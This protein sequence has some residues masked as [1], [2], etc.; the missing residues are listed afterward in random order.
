MGQAVCQQ[1]LREGYQVTSLSRRGLPPPSQSSS[2][3][4]SSWQ[5]QVDYRQGDATQKQSITNILFEENNGSDDDNDNNNSY[6]GIVHCI[7]LLL[8]GESGLGD[9]N[10][11]A[12]G[13]GSMVHN[14]EPNT[15]DA[16]TRQTAMNAIQ[17]AM[18]YAA[19]Q[20]QRTTTATTTR[21]PFCFTSAAEAGWP[22]VAG[23]NWIEQTLAPDWLQRYLQAKRA[24]ES[25]LLSSSSSSSSQQ[26]QH[27]QQ[28]ELLRPIIV[29]PSLIYSLDRPASYVPVG[30]F[31]MLNQLGLPFVDRPVTVQSLSKAIITSLDPESCVSGILRYPEIDRLAKGAN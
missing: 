25:Q 29:R 10:R 23:G 4:L 19:T 9:W 17:A 14:T 5:K 16:I 26:Q 27:E 21:L 6:V 15:Y 30:A 12:S 11:F 3:S 2:S 7:G 24:V 13:S 31:V 28:Q 20:K 8:D 22:T 18:D 1:A